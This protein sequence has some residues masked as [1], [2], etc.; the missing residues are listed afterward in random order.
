MFP[1]LASSYLISLLSDKERN[2][3][4]DDMTDEI[5][6]VPGFNG[7]LPSRHF[8]GYIEVHPG[9]FLYY[10]LVYS[11]KDPLKDPVVLW[12]NGGNDLFPKLDFFCS[13]RLQ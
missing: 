9:R 12:L 4:S 8:G 6:S 1:F 11:E 7:I 10:Y 13:H 5:L 3:G 2:G